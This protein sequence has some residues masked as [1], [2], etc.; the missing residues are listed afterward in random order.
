MWLLASPT[1]C[2]SRLILKDRGQSAADL[3]VIVYDHDADGVLLTQLSA[4]Q[5]TV[6]RVP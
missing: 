4:F 2:R 5:T 1:S 3:A 6:I